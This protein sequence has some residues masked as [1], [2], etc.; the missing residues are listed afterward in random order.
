MIDPRTEATKLRARDPSGNGTLVG[1]G[2]AAASASPVIVAQTK[3]VMTYPTVAQRF[4]ACKPVAIL[5]PEVEGGPG[6]VTAD[7]STVFALNVGAGV[8]PVGTSLI[9][10]YCGNRWVFVYNG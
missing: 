5:G 6:T 2:I 9:L 10:T 3:M 1:V 7:S 4:Y 8:P